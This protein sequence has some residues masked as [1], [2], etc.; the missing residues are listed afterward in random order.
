MPCTQKFF[1]R[2]RW[3]SS[4]KVICTKWRSN[5]NFDIGEKIMG[6]NFDQLAKEAE[7]AKTLE[8]LFGL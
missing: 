7:S 4:R 2:S 6:E 1:P 8:E 3:W 5:I